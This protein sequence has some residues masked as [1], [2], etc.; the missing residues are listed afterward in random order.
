MHNGKPFHRG[1]FDT[2][3]HEPL[4]VSIGGCSSPSIAHANTGI[5]ALGSILK[6]YSMNNSGTCSI[7]VPAERR[8]KWN[9]KQHGLKDLCQF[10]NI[11]GKPEC[12]MPGPLP[13]SG[14]N[15]LNHEREAPLLNKI[16][17]P[18]YYIFLHVIDFKLFCGFID[19]L[20]N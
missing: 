6:K 10:L 19:F 1:L 12:E 15:V 20:D 11:S 16:F 3:G 4:L 7:F 13:K 17:V 14:I 18:S 9:M 5:V 2:V 8:F